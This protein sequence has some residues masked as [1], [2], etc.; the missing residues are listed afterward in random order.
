MNKQTE[1]GLVQNYRLGEDTPYSFLCR[2]WALLIILKGSLQIRTGMSQGDYSTKEMLLLKKGALVQFSS[3]TDCEI[4]LIQIGKKIRDDTEKELFRI[5]ETY[6]ALLDLFPIIIPLDIKLAG[7]IS[8]LLATYLDPSVSM[9]FKRKSLLYELLF[10][11]QPLCAPGHNMKQTDLKEDAVS[12]ADYER[13]KRIQDYIKQHYHEA[14]TLADAAKTEHLSVQYFAKFFKNITGHTF[15][16]YLNHYRLERALEKL[17][18]TN[19]SIL[20]ISL[21]TGF[22]NVRSFIAKFQ[23]FFGETPGKF[24]RM[25]TGIL[26]PPDINDK[27]GRGINISNSFHTDMQKADIFHIKKVL[28]EMLASYNRD[29]VQI[30]ARMDKEQGW[31]RHTWKNI[32]TVGRA[33]LLLVDEIKQQL[34]DIQKDLPFRYVRFHGVFNDDMHVY[35]EDRAGN[36]KLDF[37]YVDEGLDFLYS[38][39]LK[40]FIEIGFM[41]RDLALDKEQVI[42]NEIFTVSPPK[43]MKKWQKL[44]CEF[45]KHCMNRYGADEVRTWYFEFWNEPLFWEFDWSGHRWKHS[46]VIPD[47]NGFWLA[48]FKEYLDLYKH[49][50]QALKGIDRQLRIGGPSTEMRGI[51]SG[52]WFH[53]YINYMK[54]HQCIP[55]FLTFHLYHNSNVALSDN[56]SDFQ[57]KAVQGKD[58]IT[59]IIEDVKQVLRKYRLD[60]ELHI[61]EWNRTSIPQLEEADNYGYHIDDSCHK[62]CF[63][64]ENIIQSLDMTESLGFWTFTD[65]TET[66]SGLNTQAFSNNI[67]LITHN[68]IKKAPYNLYIL[69]GKLGDILISKGEDHIITQ[70]GTR[71]QILLFYAAREFFQPEQRHIHISLDGMD[72]GIYEEKI[73]FLNEASGSSYDAWKAMGQPTSL[74]EEDIIYLKSR[75]IMDYRKSFIEISEVFEKSIYLKINEIIFIEYTKKI[76]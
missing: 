70:K 27:T 36:V 28:D 59:G 18:H 16:S 73:Y 2:E 35:K 6:Y 4:L 47:A 9:E 71:Y 57:I 1:D 38:I 3:L 53:E 63:I 17:I 65:Y 55:D 39:R 48:S 54:R 49:T 69:L 19:D 61:T 52:V 51:F 31:I 74:V 15:F 7:L 34:R 25:A 50:Y 30:H 41:P 10:H 24:R 20:D 42:L 60:Q 68:G 67:G 22:P 21:E 43:D 58:G 29:F 5:D 44:I 8:E 64:A 26:L 46:E 66:I 14:I 11:I 45:V 37:R 32:L 40:P 72:Q 12:K 13:V 62:A 75:S 76:M 56:M 23:E 33:K